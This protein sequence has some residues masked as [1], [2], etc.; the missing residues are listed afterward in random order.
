MYLIIVFQIQINTYH[1]QYYFL[2]SYYN[3]IRT[4][5]NIKNLR[6]LF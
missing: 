3:S 4:L 1:F 5:K 6:F 2:G